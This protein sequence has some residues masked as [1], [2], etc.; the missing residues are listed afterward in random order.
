MRGR[1]AHVREVRRQLTLARRI[2]AQIQALQDLLLEQAIAEELDRRGLARP[3]RKS[4]LAERLQEQLDRAGAGVAARAVAVHGGD[5]RHTAAELARTTQ[6]ASWRAYIATRMR[7]AASAR[8]ARIAEQVVETGASR[9]RVG[10]QIRALA[11]DD[12]RRGRDALIAS[13][14]IIA[15]AEGIGREYAYDEQGI[16]VVEWLAFKS[17]VW[18]RRHDL[19]AG[20]MRQRGDLYQMPRSRHRLRWPHDPQGHVSEV[21]NCRCSIAPVLAGTRAWDRWLDQSGRPRPGPE[22]DIRPAPQRMAG[23][24]LAP[25]PNRA[26]ERLVEVDRASLVSLLSRDPGFV[27]PGGGGAEIP[28]R[29]ERAREAI[30]ERQAS[31]EPFRVPS[32]AVSTAEGIA[33]IEDGRHRMAAMLEALEAA[34]QSRITVGVES[35]EQLEELRRLLRLVVD[36]D[37]S[38]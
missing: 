31:G 2:A 6:W 16:E 36:P 14:N 26:G 17:P 30:R 11:G 21:I 13:R 34:G 38:V 33:G 20:E 7:D 12:V 18:P 1:V 22:P 10:E 35:A 29:L 3:V 28:G 9:R 4:L 15:T 27:P 25:A 8:V 19:L 24:S 37:P 32:L 5:P 23:L